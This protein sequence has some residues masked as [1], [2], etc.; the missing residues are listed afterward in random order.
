LKEKCLQESA[1]RFFDDQE[2]VV[3]KI[4][5]IVKPDEVLSDSVGEVVEYSPGYF[6]EQHILEKSPKDEIYPASELLFYFPFSISRL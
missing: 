3:L 1:V 4:S 5:T 2:Y 6:M